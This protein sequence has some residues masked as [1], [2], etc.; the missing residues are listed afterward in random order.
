MECG[1]PDALVQRLRFG[2]QVCSERSNGASFQRV[3]PSVE[4]KMWYPR[5]VRCFLLK[6]R[7]MRI[8]T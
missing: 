2:H 4:D 3:V 7:K 6:R 8:Y 1:L 5:P